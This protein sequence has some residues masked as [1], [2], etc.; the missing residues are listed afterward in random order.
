M[1]SHHP[2]IKAPPRP[3]FSCAFFRHCT[4][5]QPSPSPTTPTSPTHHHP[6]LPL[7]PPS[8]P[9]PPSSPPP[10]PPATAGTKPSSSSSSS[11]S[12]TSTSQSF[13][14]WRFPLSTSPLCPSPHTQPPP[15]LHPPPPPISS[16]NLQEVFHL[17][18][19]QLSFDSSDFDRLSGLHL[20][21]RSL[22]PNP[23]AEPACPAE[24]MCRI[25]D[26]MR[27]KPGVK[28]AAKILFALCLAGD[29]RRVAVE[30][31][32]VGAVVE[33]AMEL[34]R[35]SAERALA[36][37]ELMCTVGEGAAEVRTH[38][39]AVPVM[40]SM[41]ARMDGRGREHAISILAV[42]YGGGPAS[43]AV[44]VAPPEEVARAVVLALQGDCSARCRRKGA[45]LLKLLQESEEDGRLDLP[46]EGG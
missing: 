14:Q 8:P 6:P 29:N 19:L 30:V 22:V 16:A 46:K 17:A 25:V 20:L 41:M 33:L 24:L 11:S 42:I 38:A 2:K 18:E 3:L 28:P 9:P 45:Q 26:C 36:A 27:R 40:V 39:M 23:P 21:E 1:K 44:A 13:T 32:A 4:T 31:G 35:S 7:T 15:P 37:L 12:S 43:V 34:D 10:P 5:T